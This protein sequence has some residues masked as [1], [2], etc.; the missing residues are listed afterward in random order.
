MEDLEKKV[1]NNSLENVSKPSLGDYTRK[2]IVGAVYRVGASFLTDAVYLTTIAAIGYYVSEKSDASSSIVTAASD[3]IH[4]FD[5]GKFA[6]VAAAVVG[7]NF[8]DYKL[9]VT[10]KLDRATKKLQDGIFGKSKKS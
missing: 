10:N 1:E 2:S 4:N 6:R 8:I 7:I 5:P 3:F 9:D